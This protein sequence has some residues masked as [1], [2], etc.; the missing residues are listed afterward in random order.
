[1]FFSCIF[2]NLS[3]PIKQ[4]YAGKNVFIT[5]ATGF[6]GVT[7][8]EKLLRDIPDIGTVYLLMRAK[9]GKS[10][11]QRLEELKKN[12]VFNKFKELKLEE[13]FNKIKPIEGD[14]G[15]EHLGISEADRKILINNVNVVFHSAATLDFFQTLKET[16]NINLRGTRR[17]VEL[18]KQLT[19]LESLVH[20][21]SAYVNSYITEVEEKLYPSPDNPEKI[22]DLA[23]T[24]N[25]EALKELEPK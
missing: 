24:L 13:R 5:G 6:V 10:V 8:V 16:T 25:D 2:R 23:E 21:S 12:S 18:C 11:E 14:V 3:S 9:K 1:M 17:V 20:V 4:F 19:K 15:Q 22:I 7:I